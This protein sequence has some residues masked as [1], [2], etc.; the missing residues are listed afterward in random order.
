VR[1]REEA[2]AST[3][4]HQ[5]HKSNIMKTDNRYLVFSGLT[6]PANDS[7]AKDAQSYWLPPATDRVEFEAKKRQQLAPRTT[8]NTT[9]Y[10]SSSAA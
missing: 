6:R 5:A 1:G 2:D 10:W 4:K 7:S 9:V 8:K 3:I